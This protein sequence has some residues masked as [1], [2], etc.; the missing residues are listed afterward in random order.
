MEAG[1]QEGDGRDMA[2]TFALGRNSISGRDYSKLEPIWRR[3]AKGMKGDGR[4]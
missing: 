2:G 1:G 3:G 4:E